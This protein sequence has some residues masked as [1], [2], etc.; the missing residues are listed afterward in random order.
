MQVSQRDPRA[1]KNFFRSV[2][3]CLIILI[4]LG[5]D[6]SGPIA[7]SQSDDCTP[8][9]E[10]Q[11]QLLQSVT[12]D[13]IQ[14][15]G[16]APMLTAEDVRRVVR[17]AARTVN[18][19][20]MVI[21]VVDRAGRILAVFRKS[22]VPANVI[23]EFGRVA[24]ANNLAVALARTGAFFSNDQAPL[25]SRTVRFISG[26]HFPPG[27]AFTPNAALYGIENTNRG[28]DFGGPDEMIFN[29]G[30]VVPRARSL[31]GVMEN[32]PCN[33]TDQP[34][35]GR[36][37]ATGK[38][39]LS[40]DIPYPQGLDPGGI[41]LF[42]NG[43]V[44]GGV[45]VVIGNDGEPRTSTDYATAERAAFTAACQPEILIL[46]IPSPNLPPPGVI[47]L[48]GIRLPFAEINGLML[49][50][51]PSDFRCPSPDDRPFPQPG[52][53]TWEVE[54]RDGGVVCDGW[55]I[56][57]NGSAP[58][59]APQLT[60][61]EVE[62]IV[63]QAAEGAC[64]TRA[65]IRLPPNSA[66]KMVIAVS[67]VEGNLLGLFRMPDATVFSIDVAVAKARNVVYFSRAPRPR[68]FPGLPTNVAV[69][70]TN[71]TISFGSQPLFP[72]G[73]GPGRGPFD[74]ASEGPFFRSLYLFD[75]NNRC[76][77]GSDMDAGP[78]DNRSGIVFFPGSAPLYRNGTL[79]GGLGISGDGVEQ[80][81]VVTDFGTRGFE[82][83]PEIRADQIL[84]DSPQ[85]PVRLPYLKFNRNPERQC[86]GS[87]QNR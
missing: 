53:G 87:G 7:G 75:T 43:Q 84:V 1:V 47:F 36:G 6:L 35:C 74:P 5:S 80:D 62:R 22:P 39:T 29:P 16:G 86:Q 15:P 26:I 46:P 44:A 73:I 28:C 30:K 40:D 65:A 79:V 81:D 51:V 9:L 82:A 24:D 71:R 56:G 59:I 67:D 19:T 41:P 45:G 32:L 70:I 2:G 54:P 11:N 63:R 4:L 3:L 31:R 17:N 27:I 8:C 12:T 83:P 20:R 25:S 48:D 72:P 37:I 58:G 69:A 10:E 64:R 33:G 34:G 57:P 78:P 55:L 50:P 38:A 85:G 23:A 52:E 14:A 13:C 66:A 76:S 68:D 42:K 18:D 21:A 77:Q 61:P 49:P 60:P